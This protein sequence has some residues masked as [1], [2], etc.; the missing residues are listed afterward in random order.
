MPRRKSSVR[1]GKLDQRDRGRRKKHHNCEVW[2]TE[3]ELR[4]RTTPENWDQKLD[5][6]QAWLAKE[7]PT[8]NEELVGT[9]ANMSLKQYLQDSPSIDVSPDER[10]RQLAIHWEPIC[11]AM[12]QPKGWK[13]LERFY[14]EALKFD[15][16]WSLI[17]HSM[18][19]SIRDCAGRLR[20][21]DPIQAQLLEESLKIC[22]AGIFHSP[23]CALLYTSRGRTQYEL[24]NLEASIVDAEKAIEL[25]GGQM[26][27]VLYRAHALHDL[28]R[29]AD[30]L[31]GYES[32]DISFFDGA[33]SW[34]GVLVKDQKA[35]C[36]MHLGERSQALSLFESALNSYEKNPGLLFSPQYL[37]E[38]A[39]GEL[40]Q[41][42]GGRVMNLLKQNDMIYW[43]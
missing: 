13:I 38:A 40:K 37:I 16:Q 32:V 23:K 12:P 22:S 29:F 35:S 10:L 39:Q 7:F 8:N 3:E 15:E 5:F 34:R 14:R 26:W 30:A 9:I 31:K 36:L 20:S 41:E 28:G 19:L 21:D 11:A 24:R 25:D 33:A 42:L 2:T 17:Y 18:S 1:A 4:T 6:F 43:V 27:A